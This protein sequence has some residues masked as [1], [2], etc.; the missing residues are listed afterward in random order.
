MPL[1]KCKCPFCGIDMKFGTVDGK[2][3]VQHGYPR[4]PK[5]QELD[6]KQFGI[7]FTMK[8]IEDTEKLIASGLN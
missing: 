2:I 6:P 5:V 8:V 7:E 3:S 1:T 4:C